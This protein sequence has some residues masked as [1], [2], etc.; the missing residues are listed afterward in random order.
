[1][2]DLNNLINEQQIILDELHDEIE[3]QK[4][5]IEILKE[6]NTLLK[7]EVHKLLLDQDRTLS[8]YKEIN[9]KYNNLKFNYKFLSNKEKQVVEFAERAPIETNSKEDLLKF[10]NERGVDRK[11]NFT[12]IDKKILKCIRCKD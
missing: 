6:N 2:H 10:K 7:A 3:S 9:R 5:Q 4:S 1:M 8:M 12:D 11:L